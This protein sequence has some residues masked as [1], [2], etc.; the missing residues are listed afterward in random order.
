MPEE[1]SAVE[2]R[3]KL[4]EALELDLVGPTGGLGD[5]AEVLSVP[6]SRWYLTG[7]LVPLGARPEQR[8]DETAEEEVDEAASGGDDDAAPA[9]RASGRM[10]YFPSSIGATVLV[11][12][13]TATLEVKVSWG[14]YKRRTQDECHHDAGP[15]QS[16]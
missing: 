8:R 4:V 10:R 5:P 9:E 3:T 16:S 12:T 2:V 11:G 6:P 7:F 1:M 13:E 15:G 14:D